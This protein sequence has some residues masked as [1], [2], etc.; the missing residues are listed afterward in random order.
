MSFKIM[1]RGTRCHDAQEERKKTIVTRGTHVVMQL[2]ADLRYALLTNAQ[3]QTLLIQT[4][5]RCYDYLERD[6]WVSILWLPD[7]D[8]AGGHLTQGFLEASQ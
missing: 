4:R 6:E 1:I 2:A 8:H 3:N 5:E 7:L